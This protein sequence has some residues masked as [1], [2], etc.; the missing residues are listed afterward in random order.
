MRT[1]TKDAV[2]SLRSSSDDALS[3]SISYSSQ[4]NP[5]VT[6]AG[7]TPKLVIVTSVS[8]FDCLAS[9]EFSFNMTISSPSLS[10]F[11]LQ[12]Q[13]FGNTYLNK[14]RFNYLAMAWDPEY[15]DTTVVAPALPVGL[16]DILYSGCFLSSDLAIVTTTR[17]QTFINQTLYGVLEDPS[18]TKIQSF[19]TGLKF[20]NNKDVSKKVSVKSEILP[21]TNYITQTIEVTGNT[22]LEWICLGTVVIDHTYSE[23]Y[24]EILPYDIGA[25]VLD[26][27][28]AAIDMSTFPTNYLKKFDKVDNKFFGLIELELYLGKPYQ[29]IKYLSDNIGTVQL[30]YESLASGGKM[31]YFFMAKRVCTPNTLLYSLVPTDNKCYALPCP[32]GTAQDAPLLICAPCHYSCLECS[33]LTDITCNKCDITM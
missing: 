11:T 19:I 12:F 32:A 21:N 3:F 14:L 27:V 15:T 24:Q 1:D 13:I 31:G 7:T 18:K 2:L 29:I 4:M 20:F 17:N 10:G 28:N 25:F 8:S 6:T 9:T 26:R 5:G 23:F 16:A 33:A 30:G 22:V